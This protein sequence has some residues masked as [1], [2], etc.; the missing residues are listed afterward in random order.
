[1]LAPPAPLAGRQAFPPPARPQSPPASLRHTLRCSNAPAAASFAESRTLAAAPPPNPA[2]ANQRT[3]FGSRSSHPSHA[4]RL[5]ARPSNS[6]VA[7]YRPFRRV[8]RR[9]LLSLE[10]LSHAPESIAASSC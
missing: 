1:M 3:A 2:F 7:T 8:D 6:T 9:L 10:H 4:R 5:A